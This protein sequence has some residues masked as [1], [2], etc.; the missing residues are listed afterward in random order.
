[1]ES[2]YPAQK[3]TEIGIVSRHTCHRLTQIIRRKI[4]T[5]VV[6]EKDVVWIHLFNSKVAVGFI[7]ATRLG[8]LGISQPPRAAVRCLPR[9]L[10]RHTAVH[11][12]VPTPATAIVIVGNIHNQVRIAGIIV[13]VLAQSVVHEG[14]VVLVARRPNL[15]ATRTR[16]FIRALRYLQTFGYPHQSAGG[17]TGHRQNRHCTTRRAAGCTWYCGSRCGGGSGSAR[18]SGRRGCSGNDSSD[19]GGCDACK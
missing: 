15:P 9:A 1:M 18:G 11:G 5:V 10:L 16:I 6:I 17:V 19:S 7:I 4:P 13:N 8:M 2:A 14:P 12:I 3:T